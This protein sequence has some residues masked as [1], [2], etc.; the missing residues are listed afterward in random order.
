[1]IGLL[2]ACDWL[3]H[4]AHSSWL[5][6]GSREVM[7]LKKTTDSRELTLSS[8]SEIGTLPGSAAAGELQ[9]VDCP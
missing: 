4:R 9:L 6:A 2:R 7:V 3:E 5:E 8:L 1:M